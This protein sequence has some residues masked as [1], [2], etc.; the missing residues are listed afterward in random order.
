MITPITAIVAIRGQIVAVVVS[1]PVV[2]AS[3]MLL[4][5]T[6]SR[7]P[8]RKI[9]INRVITC[10]LETNLSKHTSFIFQWKYRY[11]INIYFY[12]SRLFPLVCSGR[13]KKIIILVLLY[14]SN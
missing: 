8:A 12:C 13:F 6:G 11:R 1:Q 5:D 3:K 14:Y 9:A 2:L 10:S 4:I 7:T